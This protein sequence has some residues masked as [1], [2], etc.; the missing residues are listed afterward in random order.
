MRLSNKSIYALRALFDLG[1][2]A[3]AQPVQLRDV[4]ERQSIPTRF[5]EQILLELKR[6]RIVRS[7]RG[8]GGGYLLAHAP[9]EISVQDVFE[10][11]GELPQV[12]ELEGGREHV[13]DQM[14]ASLM[15]QMIAN[16]QSQT[17]ADLVDAARLAGVPHAGYE[18][19]VYVI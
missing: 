9:S 1:Y 5:L 8:P 6:A 14:C 3:G 15:A 7:K 4:A 2:H 18:E 11:L 13:A 12:P 17:I 10:A 19:F 16:L